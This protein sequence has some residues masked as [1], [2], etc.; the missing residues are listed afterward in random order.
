MSHCLHTYRLMYIP[1]VKILYIQQQQCVKIIGTRHRN[2]ESCVFKHLIIR[3]LWTIYWIFLGSLYWEL[4]AKK[5][6]ETQSL[7]I[8]SDFIIFLFFNLQ[9][10]NC[11]KFDVLTSSRSNSS[12][13]FK[14]IILKTNKH[15]AYY[16]NINL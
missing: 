5:R 15:K 16:F 11:K 1:N 6:Y 12:S 9:A 8:I 4:P 2:C 14:T 13:I 7:V 10:Q 3:V